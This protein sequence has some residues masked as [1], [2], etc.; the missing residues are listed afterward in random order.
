MAL[1]RPARDAIIA[2][3]VL[4]VIAALVA[5]FILWVKSNRVKRQVRVD[6]AIRL[7]TAA[8]KT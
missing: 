4:A 1:S 3:S 5:A 6:E 2:F 7:W 8:R